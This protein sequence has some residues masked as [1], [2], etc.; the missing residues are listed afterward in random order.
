MVSSVLCHSLCERCRSPN[1]NRPIL[2]QNQPT[3]NSAPSPTPSAVSILSPLRPSAA[4]L[5]Q[6]P[7]VPLHH[8]KTLVVPRFP[9]F[10]LP[11]FLP[12]STMVQGRVPAK[13]TGPDGGGMGITGPRGGGEQGARG[14]PGYKKRPK[15]CEISC[16]RSLFSLFISQK[17]SVLWENQSF[18]NGRTTRD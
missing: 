7:A 16:F 2:P 14:M 17:R 3:Y 8:L 10:F 18:F 12:I 4:C 11:V 1:E 13:P 9:G 15:A 5:Q 6:P